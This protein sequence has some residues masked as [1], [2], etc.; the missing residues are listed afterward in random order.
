MYNIIPTFLKF[1]PIRYPIAAVAQTF[2]A[3]TDA[4]FDGLAF[5][6]AAVPFAGGTKTLS[7]DPNTYAHKK[8][9]QR[10]FHLNLSHSPNPSK[11][12]QLKTEM[13]GLSCSKAYIRNRRP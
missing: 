3:P 1:L 6:L 7:T 9:P 10:Y 12:H 4:S 11:S 2:T 8:L 5:P 13:C